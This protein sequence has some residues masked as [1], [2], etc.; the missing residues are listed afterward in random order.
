MLSNL[1][2]LMKDV[3]HIF[4]D[5]DHT[6]WDFEKNSSEA[7]TELFDQFDL[8]K[9]IKSLPD[10]LEE[11]QK[12]NA[13]YW[14]RYNKGEIDKQTVRYGRFFDIFSNY[15]IEDYKDLAVKFAD[16]YLI[17]APTKK[18]IFPFTHDVLTY[19]KLK[20]RLHIITNGFKEVQTIKMSTTNLNEYF[21]VIICSEDVGVNKPNPKIFYEALKKSGSSISESL[22]IGDTYEADILG[23]QNIGMKTIHFNPKKEPKKTESIE[24]HCLSELKRLL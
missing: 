17:I 14:H 16:E 2:G 22:M 13:V 12:V 20:Y 21:D 19:L 1:F 24:I 9:K 7:I 8:H 18:N 11:Y 15:K 10:F 5:L 6:L 23:A 3:R 4:F